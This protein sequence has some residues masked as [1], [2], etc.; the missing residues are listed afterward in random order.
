VIGPVVTDINGSLEQAW[1][2]EDV[3]DQAKPSRAALGRAASET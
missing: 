1:A 2:L 3:T